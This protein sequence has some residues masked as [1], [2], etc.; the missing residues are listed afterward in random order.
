M[1]MLRWV[2]ALTLVTMLATVTCGSVKAQTIPDL[3]RISELLY[4]FEGNLNWSVR[5]IEAAEDQRDPPPRDNK[6][7]ISS[8][9]E[10]LRATVNI[11]KKKSETLTRIDL[12]RNYPINDR[13]LRR[14]K[15]NK[16]TMILV[17]GVADLES[18]IQSKSTL[19]DLNARLDK[20]VFFMSFVAD[21][22]AEASS[23]IPNH[24]LRTIFTSEW[25]DIK[26]QYIPSVQRI[27]N[28]V[29]DIT[30]RNKA[31]VTELSRKITEEIDFLLPLLKKEQSEIS[32]ERNQYKLE[33][34]ELK[35]MDDSR[36]RI[37]DEIVQNRKKLSSNSVTISRLNDAIRTN[38]AI[39][40]KQNN[41]IP[42]LES[43]IWALSARLSDSYSFCP[44]KRTYN[45]CNHTKEKKRWDKRQRDY[46]DKRSAVVSKVSKAKNL[47]SRKKNENKKLEARISKLEDENSSIRSKIRLDER[48]HKQLKEK[49]DEKRQ[50][51]WGRLWESKSTAIYD[52]SVGN[53]DA[54]LE[55][56]KTI[57]GVN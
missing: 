28:D 6:E 18:L 16:N 30:N 11:A 27:Q 48:R 13:E 23:Y 39:I 14:F 37:M 49:A 12:D 35:R 33:L 42:Q 55:A 4:R 19:D 9:I 45:N 2:K 24:V 7:S 38:S 41:I 3:L 5:A 34:E 50:E 17:K 53:V 10:K 29:V 51:L 46:N 8:Q 1:W 15:L 40:Q 32:E 47:L 20:A 25:Y 43:E 21:L 44:N 54:L 56:K 36:D 31:G 26:T 22:I 52:S 57:E